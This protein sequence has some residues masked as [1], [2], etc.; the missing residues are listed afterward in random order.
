MLSDASFKDGDTKRVLQR[1]A[2]RSFGP[3]VQRIV[4]RK[5]TSLSAAERIGGLADP[6]G[7]RLEKLKGDRAGPYSIRVEGTMTFEVEEIR[8]RAT[9]EEVEPPAAA[10]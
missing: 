8:L 2:V 6:P 10:S 7:N 9:L 5:R 1:P 4:W 3:D